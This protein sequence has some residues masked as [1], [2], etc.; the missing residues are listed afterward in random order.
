M[1][2]SYVRKYRQSQRT[3][4]E[5]FV[6]VLQVLHYWISPL[7]KNSQGNEEMEVT[8]LVIGPEN[9]PQTESIHPWE[10][11][12]IPNKQHAEKEEEIGR[13][14]FL[15]MDIEFRIKDLNKVIECE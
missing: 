4:F 7:L 9:L 5:D 15:K 14:G 10:L 8:A 11:A 6:K 2:S 3:E 12:F 1:I 13:I